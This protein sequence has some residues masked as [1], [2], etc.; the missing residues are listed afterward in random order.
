MDFKDTRCEDVV[1]IHGPD[2]GSYEHGNKPWAPVKGS[3]F[4]Y[5]LKTYKLPRKMTPP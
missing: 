1:F 5:S 2:L 3:D 4:I